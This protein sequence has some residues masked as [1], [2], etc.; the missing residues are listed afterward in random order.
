MLSCPTDSDI[1]LRFQGGAG[2]GGLDVSFNAPAA[3]CLDDD[4]ANHMAH[5][6]PLH[7]RSANNKGVKMKPFR[8]AVVEDGSCCIPSNV[9]CSET[10][11]NPFGLGILVERKA[12]AKSPLSAIA[13]PQA[14]AVS[15]PS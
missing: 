15:M 14:P 3:F 2:V 4:I 9:D 8:G 10:Q 7:L 5:T 1:P 6:M 11:P 12:Y 13:V